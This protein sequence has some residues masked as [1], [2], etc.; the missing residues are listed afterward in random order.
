M[1]DKQKIKNLENRIHRLNEIGMALSTESDSN[2]LFEMILEEARNI[3]NADGRTL[4]SKN[5]EGNL[6]FEILRNDTMNTIMGGSSNK[7]IP[8]DP[9]K[10][11]VDDSTPNQSNVSAYVALTGE[12]VNIKDAY[13]E[14]GFD[15]SG[16]KSYDEKTG[17]HSKSFLTVPLK[18]HENEIIGVMQLINA[19]DEDNEVV[20]FDKDMQEQIESL[21]SQGAV[22]LTNKKLVGELKTLFE[23]FIQLIATA[24]DKKSEY[25]GGHCSRVP[26]ITMMLA[27]AVAKTTSG[28]YKDFS[29]TEE[30]RYELYIAAWLH[31]CGKVATPPHVVDKGTKLETIFDRIELVKTRMEI[32]KRDVEIDFLKRQL[33]GSLPEFDEKYTE[34]INEIDEN[35][36]FIEACNIG[37]EFMKSELQDKIVA[38]SKQ[39]LFL[40]NKEMNILTDNEVRNLNITK[41]TLLPEERDIINDHISITIDML[42]ELPYPKNLKNIPEFAGGHHEKMDGTGYPKGLKADQMSPQAKIMAIADIYEALTAADRPYKEGKKLS[43][44]MRIMGFMKND[45]HIDEDLFE[46]FVNSGVYKKYAEDHVA[47]NQIDQIDEKA[48]LGIK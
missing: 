32:L 1:N 14:A 4:Y 42:E 44:A 40:N 38:I 8:F 37:G 30:E 5:K 33:N 35:I 21:A 7:K 34:A 48:V 19:R 24:I 2:K 25:T 41:G 46:I 22:A 29:M 45:Y 3:T 47:S 15:F 17:Y 13:Q 12:T 9:V 11:W 28:K 6:K 31:D 26:V 39:K 23:A 18:N 27:D 20:P 16:T 43:Q 36:K 10:L